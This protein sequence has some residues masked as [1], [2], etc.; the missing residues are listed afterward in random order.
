M[1]MAEVEQPGL[2][3]SWLTHIRTSSMISSSVVRCRMRVIATRCDP[4]GVARTRF[5]VATMMRAWKFCERV[6]VCREVPGDRVMRQSH[7]WPAHRPGR[8][9]RAQARPVLR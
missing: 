5:Q 8:E 7:V 2:L 9:G 4:P 6:E 1:T 3:A